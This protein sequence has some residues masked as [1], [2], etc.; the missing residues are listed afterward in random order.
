[1]DGDSSPWVTIDLHQYRLAPV[2]SRFCVLVYNSKVW[3]TADLD[4]RLTVCQA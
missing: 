4:L 1:M 3:D 2:T